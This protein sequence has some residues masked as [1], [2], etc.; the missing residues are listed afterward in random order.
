METDKPRIAILMAV[1]EPQMDWL[2]E[3]LKSLERQTYPN[4]HLYIRDDGSSTV[5]FEEIEACVENCIHSFP[6]VIRRN[7]EN[8]GSNLT[9]QRL[10]QEA[11]GDCF[12]YCD[13]DDVWLPEKLA[14]LQEELEGTES[15]S[16]GRCWCARI[17]ALLTG[18]GGRWRTV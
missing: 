4:L 14:V 10:T 5:P 6:Y 9:F 18:R 11:E 16:I 15:S 7:E 3:Q 17:C 8:L 1:Y 12:A 2:R 13:Q